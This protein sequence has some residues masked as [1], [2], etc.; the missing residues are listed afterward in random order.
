MHRAWDLG[1]GDDT[2]VIWFSALRLAAPDPR[3]A[4]RHPA[5]VS[6]G[7]AMRFSGATKSEV[8]SMASITSRMTPK[9]RNGDLDERE[10]RQCLHWVSSRMLVPMATIDDGI[11]A[12]RRTLP[13]CVFHP[14]TEHG[15]YRRSRAIPAR[16]GRRKEVLPSLR[17]PRL[18]LA[19]SRRIPI[20][21]HE[22]ASGA[23]AETPGRR[24]RKVGAFRPPLSRA[25]E[26]SSYEEKAN[27][28]AR[29]W[30]GFLC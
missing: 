11:N 25:V 30:L 23:A 2:V 7:I 22:L 15:R 13:L 12:A 9:S 16:V 14:R 8:G 19:P 18:D 6:N 21:E 26:A 5:S 24:S 17:R 28:K 3:R 1:V 27:H 29:P 20:P 10:S 4:R